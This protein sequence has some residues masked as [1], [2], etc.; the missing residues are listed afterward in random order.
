MNTRPFAFKEDSIEQLGDQMGAHDSQRLGSFRFHFG[1]DRWTW[2]P[3]VEQ[4]HGYLPGT[5][6][7][8]TLL[9]LSHVHPDDERRVAAHLYDVRRTGDPFSSHHRI[10]DTRHR[11]RDVVMIGVPFYDSFGALAG[12]HGFY[13]DATPATD[14][15][16][17]SS[18]AAQLLDL[19]AAHHRREGRR[20]QIRAATRC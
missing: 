4:M 6:A 12:M 13:L 18:S 3:Q 10:V 19:A 1:N 15:S 11:V 7:P 17:F 5:T 20:Q 14:S 8:G 16:G 9:V 2:S